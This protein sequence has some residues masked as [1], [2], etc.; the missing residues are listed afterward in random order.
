M[1]ELNNKVVHGVNASHL[2]TD[3]WPFL[4]GWIGPKLYLRRTKIGLIIKEN[5]LEP[6]RK[7]VSEFKGSDKLVQVAGRTQLQDHPKCHCVKQLNHHID[8]WMS[9][10]Y[11]FGEGINQ[12]HAKVMFTRTLPDSTRA[13]IYYRPEVEAMDLLRLKDWIRH[14]TL[15]EHTEDIVQQHSKPGTVTSLPSKGTEEPPVATLGGGAHLDE[16]AMQHKG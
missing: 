9:L 11:Q 16:Q 6:R 1:H 12:E 2:S 13:E 5:R 15:L 10:F 8:D 14:Q 4:L 3:L 7:P